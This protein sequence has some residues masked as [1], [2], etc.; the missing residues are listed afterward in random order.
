MFDEHF[1]VVSIHQ[2]IQDYLTPEMGLNDMYDASPNQVR[3]NVE[4]SKYG[5]MP[6][7]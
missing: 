6:K 7:L 5:S 3:E 4:R 1:L 2:P